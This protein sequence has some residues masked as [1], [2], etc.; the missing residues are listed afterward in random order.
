MG[1]GVPFFLAAV[2]LNWYLAGAQRMRRWLRP[3]ERASGALLVAI[4][5]LLVTGKFTILSHFF[6][7]LGTF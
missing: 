4:G 3:I 1:L 7:G 2:A 6:A 5:V